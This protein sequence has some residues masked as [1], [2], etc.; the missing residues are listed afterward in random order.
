MHNLLALQPTEKQSCWGQACILTQSDSY[1]LPSPAAL[2][3]L[4]AASVASNPQTHNFQCMVVHTLSL[5][6]DAAGAE[7]HN[8]R[9][10]ANALHLVCAVLKHA[11]Q[12][13]SQQ[14]AQHAVQQAAP[15]LPPV[16]PASHQAPPSLQILGDLFEMPATLPLPQDFLQAG[17]AKARDAFGIQ[18][19]TGLLTWHTEGILAGALLMP[20]LPASQD[21]MRCRAA[22]TYVF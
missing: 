13:A 14:A 7:G 19:Y 17:K 12:Q 18:S 1:H 5:L 20:A 10:A 15:S 11:T 2:H 3:Q 4:F 16:V 22:S 21:L 8:R 9:S 6:S